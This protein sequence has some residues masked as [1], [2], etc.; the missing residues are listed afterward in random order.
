M[1][2][3]TLPVPGSAR[4]LAFRRSGSRCAVHRST[5]FLRLALFAAGGR[6]SVRLAAAASVAS[7]T[8]A[9]NSALRF[10]APAAYRPGRSFLWA[11]RISGRSWNIRGHPR[12]RSARGDHVGEARPA[13]APAAG[14]GPTFPGPRLFSFAPP[15][16][17]LLLLLRPIGPIPPQLGPPSP[18]AEPRKIHRSVLELMPAE[19]VPTHSRDPSNTETPQHAGD[20]SESFLPAPP[21]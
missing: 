14:C 4:L 10:P 21:S 7:L 17:A 18:S 1:R 9:V 3:S 13:P 6:D 15:R 12:S 20:R 16:P 8:W 19:F 2:R 11:P 5:V